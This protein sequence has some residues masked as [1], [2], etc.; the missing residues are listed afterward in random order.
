[1]KSHVFSFNL[2]ICF[3]IKAELQKY[4]GNISGQFGYINSL[5]PV[6]PLQP[7]NKVL[8]SD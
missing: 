5:Y 3:N 8:L 1:V 7:P 4:S 2:R 6:K